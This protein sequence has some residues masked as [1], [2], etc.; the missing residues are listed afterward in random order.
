MIDM[1]NILY[2]TDFSRC[3]EQAFGHAVYF[4]DRY[5]AKLHMLH[6]LVLHDDDPFNPAYHFPDKA[7]IQN[8]FKEIAKEKSA[9][10]RKTH[11]TENIE[12]LEIQQRGVFPAQ[13]ILEYAEE[14]DIDLVVMGTHGRRGL[15]HLFLGSVAEEVIRHTTCP[16]LTLKDQKT[17]VAVHKINTILV[18]IDFSPFTQKS[19]SVAKEMAV[20][21]SARLQL[22]HIVEELVH[23]AIYLSGRS[24]IFE[25][26]PDIKS[27]SESALHDILD[28]T[29]GEKP[30]ADLHVVEGRATRDIVQF[31]EEHQSDLIVIASHG[32]TGIDHLFLGGVSEKVVRTS[33][34]PVLTI[35]VYDKSAT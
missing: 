7:T 22:L 25:I 13:V 27:K 4:A 18:P 2:T 1:K 29:R 34:I 5:G 9:T 26:M 31:A 23:P 35:K 3:A 28:K 17:P 6:A 19:L 21:L 8:K 16:V 10:L 12:V 11:K 24:S 30:D 15:G 32:L 14:N 20:E 33:T